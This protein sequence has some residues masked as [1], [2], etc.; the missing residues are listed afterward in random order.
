MS[1]PIV[2]H[3]GNYLRK[4][5]YIDDGFVDIVSFWKDEETDRV[6]LPLTDIEKLHFAMV[7]SGNIA[8]LI[9]ERKPTLFQQ[10]MGWF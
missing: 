10:F 5:A 9:P 8:E 2:L 6:T 4:R 1:K 3:E 7:E